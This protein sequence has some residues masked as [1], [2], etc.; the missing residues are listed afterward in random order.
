[1]NL[2]YLNVSLISFRP[3]SFTVLAFNG[4]FL[5]TYT[6]SK[7]FIKVIVDILAINKNYIAT[8]SVV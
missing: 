4:N 1:L 2:S 3:S 7:D 6:E 8:N 5:K